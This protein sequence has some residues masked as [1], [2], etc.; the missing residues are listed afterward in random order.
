MAEAGGGRRNG[1]II[2]A[3]LGALAVIVAALYAVPQLFHLP[4]TNAKP[5]RI[6]SNSFFKIKVGEN[7]PFLSMAKGGKEPYQYAWDFGDGGVSLLQNTTHVYTKE[8]T[9]RVALTVTDSNGVKAYA[10][11]DVDVFP[12]NANITRAPDILRY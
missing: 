5:L 1:I 12:P 10:V 4:D 9:Y 2:F 7:S 3:S 6:A 8:G 11:H